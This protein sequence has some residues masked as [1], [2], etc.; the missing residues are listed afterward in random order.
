VRLHVHSY[1][2]AGSPAIV[3]VHGVTGH[4]ERFRRLAQERLRDRHVVA[5]DLRGHGRSG[6]EPPWNIE[7]H[8]DD[9]AETADRLGIGPA[10]WIGFSFGGRLVAELAHEHPARVERL[11]LLDPALR[12]PPD[13]AQEAADG[14]LAEVTFA[15]PEEAIETRYAAGTLISTPR[16]LLEEEMAQALVPI[17]DGRFRYRYS[18]AAAVGAW[19]EMARPAPP[20]AELPTLFVLGTE[21][22]VPNDEH[23]RRYRAALGDDLGLLEIRSG[24]SLLWDAFGETA[25][26]VARFVA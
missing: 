26:A 25:D 5:V 10:P 15:S 11:A 17:G 6:Y 2:D 13:F 16:E 22:Y 8:V 3:C 21:S 12:L 7:T 20:V 23:V 18:R 24:H 14:E 19:G 1:G 4:G 9:L